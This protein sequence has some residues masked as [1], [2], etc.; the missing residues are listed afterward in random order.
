MIPARTSKRYFDKTKLLIISDKTPTHVQLGDLPSYLSSGDLVVVNHSGTLPSSFRGKITRT[1]ES[2]E[3][4]LAAFQ[5]SNVHNLQNWLAFS[6]GAGDWKT[7]T[8]KRGLVPK[9]IEGDTI[10]FS[11]DLSAR[12][13]EVKHERLLR[14]KFLSDHL[15]QALH[16]HGCPIQYSYLSS[17]LKIWDQQTIFSGPSI[18]VEPPS[19]GFQFTWDMI[20]RLRKKGVR[21]ASILHSAG[22]TSTGSVELDALLPL[23]EWYEV[24]EEAAQEVRLAKRH[25]KKVLALGT[26][27]LRALESS[28]RQGEVQASNGLTNLKIHPKYKLQTATSLFT[29][30]H[31]IGTSHMEILNA[32]CGCDTVIEAYREANEYG[33]KGHEY[34]DV[35]LLDCMA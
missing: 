14:I 7:P 32:F 27:V 5:G 4:R 8:E 23:D 15:E 29:G 33:Y 28:V 9:L 26:T 11:Q 22:I 16:L 30:M 12:I 13:V 31:E 17:N 2:V 35:T 18:S 24:S 1:Q 19:A 20:F 25:G 3:I 10:V 34:G 6:F 21:I